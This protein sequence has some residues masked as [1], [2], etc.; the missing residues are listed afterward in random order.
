MRTLLCATCVFVLLAAGEAAAV[1]GCT[2]MT[3]N[4]TTGH[5]QIICTA[6]QHGDLPECTER[7]GGDRTECTTTYEYECPVGVNSQD[8]G[9]A[10]P[11]QKTGFG[12]VAAL[13]GN[14]TQCTSGQLLTL[15]IT[16]GGV[17]VANPTINPT[18]SVGAAGQLVPGVTFNVDNDASHQFPQ[19]PIGGGVPNSPNF[20]GDDYRWADNA[21]V[22]IERAPGRYRW[23][24][25]TD[26]EKDRQDENAAWSYKFVSWVR[27][28]STAQE[29]CACGFDVLVAWPPNGPPV[30]NYVQDA[31]YSHNCNF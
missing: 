11:S 12:I 4:H 9:A 8:L 27:G 26:Q 13:T 20:G 15:T 1:C 14:E 21:A 25:N 18:N 5:T 3:V 23:W 30:T 29:S 19:Y 7:T 31:T 28:S 6:T 17:T 10:M 22:L 2:G 16:S 24:D